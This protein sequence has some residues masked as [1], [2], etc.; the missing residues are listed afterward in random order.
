M[1]IKNKMLAILLSTT[2]VLPMVGCDTNVK[3][4]GKEIISVQ[5]YQQEEVNPKTEAISE[6][7]EP[8]TY[9]NYAQ[10]SD[11]EIL[12]L[13]LTGEYTLSVN[14]VPYKYN[15]EDML[16]V[17]CDN[18]PQYKVEHYQGT[19]YLVQVYK[20]NN[21][22]TFSV[23]TLDN[24]IDIVEFNFDGYN[25]TGDNASV[26]MAQ[27]IY[28]T[29]FN[30]EDGSLTKKQ[31]QTKD[32]SKENISKEET[33]KQETKK[34]EKKQETPKTCKWC[35]TNQLPSGSGENDKCSECKQ[36][37]WNFDCNDCGKN[38]SLNEY[39]SYGHDTGFCP[40]CYDKYIKSTSNN[41]VDH[42]TYYCDRCSKDITYKNFA[43][44]IGGYDYLCEA[45][46]MELNY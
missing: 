41:D 28:N 7:Q 5:D 40:S 13:I 18:K 26:V 23:D 3:L 30:T 35:Y 21:Y 15:T 12:S 4:F 19:M 42:K 29:H 27:Y 16:K 6:Q 9:E 8:K 1:N 46:C 37:S 33:K 39:W 17:L 43:Q 36:E 10:Y 25:A 14:N 32:N 31:Q 45:C 34:E 11:E 24:A 44:N 22:V 2:M 20:D 38:M